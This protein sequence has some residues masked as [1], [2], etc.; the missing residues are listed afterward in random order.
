MSDLKAAVIA[1]ILVPVTIT[2]QVVGT[3]TP[4]VGQM[5]PSAQ[6]IALSAPQTMSQASLSM[7]QSGLLPIFAVDMEF[8]RSWIDGSDVPSKLPQ[9]SHSGVNDT[10][11]QAWGVLRAG[12]FSTI[13]FPLDIGDPQATTRLS[14][15][16]LW[17]KTNNVSL[18]PILKIAGDN[19]QDNALAAATSAFAAAIVSRLRTAQ[20]LTDYA[21][22]SYYEIEDAMNHAGLHPNL[23]PERAAQIL[24]TAA[25][26]LR[27][28]ESQALQGSGMQATPIMISASFDYELIRQNG[29]AG[30]TLDPGAV[31]KAQAALKEFLSP[32]S[33]ANIE[34][35]NVE[36]FPSSISS[37]EVNQFPVLLRELRTAFPDKQLTLTTGFS[38]AFH[39]ADQQSLFLAMTVTNLAGF[40][41][42][43]GVNSHFL[44]PIFRQAFSGPNADNKPPE[45][46]G[47]PTQWNWTEKCQQL[48]KMWSQGTKSEDL[49]WWLNKVQD[50]M[51]LL[52]LQPNG[53][54]GMNVV[55]LPSEQVFQQISTSVAQATQSVVSQASLPVAQSFVPP[56]TTSGILQGAAQMGQAGQQYP[57]SPN[58]ATP[59]FNATPT[60]LSNY[61]SIPAGL[62]AAAPNG[63]SPSQQF[64]F[65]LLQQITTQLTTSLASK[66]TSSKGPGMQSQSFGYP[67]VSLGQSVSTSLAPSQ[68]PIGTAN[69]L[70]PNNSANPLPAPQVYP[71]I[72]N[73]IPTTITPFQPQPGI[74]SSGTTITAWL[75]PQDVS[76]DSTT[77]AIG[78]SVHITAQIHN[79]G[80]DLSGLGVLLVDPSNGSAPN[81]G[82]QQGIT[83]PRSGIARV[84]LTWTASG[85]SSAGQ[86]VMSLLVLDG[87]NTQI[88][89][90]PVPM[91]TVVAGS[92]QDTN[93]NV[94]QTPLPSNS[95][96][97]P[98]S[99]P[100]PATAQTGAASTSPPIPSFSVTSPQAV[101]AGTTAS[102]RNSANVAVSA[103]PPST[104]T[105]GANPQLTS[106]QSANSNSSPASIASPQMGVH[107]VLSS[108]SGMATTPAAT[109]PVGVPASS[110][111]NG[112]TAA[113]ITVSPAP[114]VPVRPGPGTAV[115]PKA[116]LNANGPIRSGSTEAAA[117]PQAGSA[118]STRGPGAG[119]AAL[120]ASS[121]NIPTRPGP[122]GPAAAFSPVSGIPPR[123]GPSSGATTPASTVGVHPP[124]NS[125]L[126]RPGPGNRAEDN[127]RGGVAIAQAGAGTPVPA[128][129]YVDLSVSI[130]DIRVIPSPPRSGQPTSFIVVVHNLGTLDA[131][132]ASIVFKLVADGRQLA[133]SQPLMFDVA[134]QGTYQGRWSFQA[135][136]SKGTESQALQLGVVV[137]F[138]GDVNPA[139]NGAMLSF[140]LAPENQLRR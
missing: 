6:Q 57:V 61:V 125:A 8:D 23:T 90:V 31:Q 126:A 12:G 75:S 134:A 13:R 14:N 44:G 17:G 119:V 43:D 70:L 3:T 98:P 42:S 67:G 103:V 105:P 28:S 47:D 136:L 123:P 112:A 124:I 51:G 101:A 10:F 109:A 71:P 133:I 130:A 46:I 139:N 87:S 36:W 132:G 96:A 62:Q 76:V 18:I 63:A 48:T 50:N 138:A 97:A 135:P 111:A 128:H 26:A 33:K 82:M 100:L 120:T 140:T 131:H 88:A 80:V 9:Y 27:K 83:V 59:T 129:G 113:L 116:P 5:A 16:C 84:Q 37:G 117:F 34:S 49:A 66:L 69:N 122:S 55:P 22:I 94:A 32:F 107:N 38:S 15:L 30:V 54:G 60:S 39:T 45:G 7:S 29:I 91:I 41:S 114:T 95:F 121:D 77:V 81:Q 64:L 102:S 137:I 92:G 52:S 19:P 104:S 99:S 89:T 72:S 78:Q 40:R 115:T 21:Q 56:A 86:H 93:P 53:S 68:S 58:Q 73:G 11:Q 1:L 106:L 4:P 108:P 35:F 25:D 85:Q 127:N 2:G 65:T 118:P 24:L 20:Q 79:A 74:A 110:G